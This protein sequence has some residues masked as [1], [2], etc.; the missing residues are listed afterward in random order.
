MEHIEYLANLLATR[1]NLQLISGSVTKGRE[2][3]E[4]V[5]GEQE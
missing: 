3:R 1:I 5:Q 4:Y 2:I